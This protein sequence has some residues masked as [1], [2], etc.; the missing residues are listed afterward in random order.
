MKNIKVRYEMII[1]MFRRD[2]INRWEINSYIVDEN[3]MTRF[4]ELLFIF[5]YKKPQQNKIEKYF[6]ND[7]SSNLLSA[8]EIKESEF[9]VCYVLVVWLIGWCI[10]WERSCDWYDK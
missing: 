9:Q 8:Q 5:I 2:E 10:V 1:E 3:E 4:L 7:T 6:N